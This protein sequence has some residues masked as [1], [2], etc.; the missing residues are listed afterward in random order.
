MTMS[1]FSKIKMTALGGAVA[2]GLGA[3]GTVLADNHGHSHADGSA[4]GARQTAMHMIGDHMKAL[5]AV[6]KGEAEAD[7]ATA[8]HAKSLHALAAA[9]KFMFMTEGDMPEMS[10][11]KAEI[12]TDWAGFEKAADAFTTA[13]AALIPAAAGGDPA[14]IGA[15]LGE[16]GKTCGGCHKPFRGPDK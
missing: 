6:A 13:T 5:G 7:A 3:A 1:R 12:W 16:V 9:T 4:F 8:V 10:R 2:L 14:A 15:A 11:A